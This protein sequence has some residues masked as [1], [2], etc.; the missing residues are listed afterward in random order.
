MSTTN[1]VYD[2][3]HASN[4]VRYTIRKAPIFI[5]AYVN[6]IWVVKPSQVRKVII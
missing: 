3:L 5:L 2:Y 4:D 6:Y 1:D